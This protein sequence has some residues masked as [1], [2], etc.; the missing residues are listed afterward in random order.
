MTHQFQAPFPWFGGKRRVAPIVWERFGSVSNYCEPFFGSGAVLLGRP[1]WTPGMTETGND[2]DGFLANFWRSVTYAPDET[3]RYA[4]W[5]VNENDLH[6]RHAWLKP[7]RAELSAR[8]EGD[9]DYYDAK[10][11]GWWVWGIC[12]WIGHG[13]CDDGVSGPWVVE[14]GELVFR[15]GEKGN[16]RPIPHVGR[17][18]GINRQLPR[19]GNRGE[20][21]QEWFRALSGRLRGVRV[22]CGDWRRILGPTPTEKFGLT[23]IFLDPPYSSED[24][25]PKVYAEES[26]SVAHDVREWALEHGDNPLLRIA[27]CGYEGEHDMP[28]SWECVPWKTGGGYASQGSNGSVNANKERIWFSPACLGIEKAQMGLN[29]DLAI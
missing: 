10:L 18:Q 24:R 7:R 23:A 28:D 12:S 5:P 20:F 4:D 8:L 9:P 29:F 25:D 3:A 26:L 22:C 6:A 13:W 11:A 14:D 15:P 2:L 16:N 21:I 19:L 1:D 27:L 17:G